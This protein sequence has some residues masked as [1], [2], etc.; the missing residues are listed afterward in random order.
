M[1]ELLAHQRDLLHTIETTRASRILVRSPVGA[2]STEVLVHFAAKRAAAG[3]FV[4]VTPPAT[5]L[6]E[7]WT[8]R[9]SDAGT[10]SVRAIRHPSELLV[11]FDEAAGGVDLVATGVM[12]VA[13]DL[14]KRFTDLKRFRQLA[15]DILIGDEVNGSP[16][17][18]RIRSLSA[19][20]QRA[21]RA[22]ALSHTARD[23]SWLP[24]AETIEW[25]LDW[26][27]PRP[28]IRIVRFALGHAEVDALARGSELLQRT[29][30]PSD[31]S[32]TRP[33]LYGSLLHLRARLGQAQLVVDG[34]PALSAPRRPEV[35]LDEVWTAI[36]T[37]E[38]LGP[39]PRLAI[40]E[41]EVQ[42]VIQQGRSCCVLVERVYDADYIA[43]DLRDKGYDVDVVTGSTPIP[44]RQS[45]LDEVSVTVATTAVMAL[46]SLPRETVWVWWTLPSTSAELD[47]R[48]IMAA[49]TSGSE[50]V[51]LAAA[52]TSP[53][54]DDLLSALN[55]DDL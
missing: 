32:L 37:L 5:A 9:L 27:P 24:D 31:Q 6:T 40:L 46:G 12:V 16:N 20:A 33:G 2:G 29:S 51:A 44:Q 18:Q 39:D 28:P 22:I 34:D 50:I 7:Q 23:V 3:D 25:A 54:E 13:V 15:P 8:R 11:M 35:E 48:L 49:T 17:S 43:G 45:P 38:E 47:R 10:E 30:T 52:P 19:L 42:T 14:L 21:V 1:R 53:H 41:E 55:S 4:I 36:D 26:A